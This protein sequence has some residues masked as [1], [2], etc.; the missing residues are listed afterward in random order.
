MTFESHTNLGIIDDVISEP[1]RS[2][3]LT[4][5][6]AGGPVPGPAEAH[7]RRRVKGK[8]KGN[9]ADQFCIYRTSDGGNIPTMAIEYKA[10][11]KLS[12]DEVVM[13]LASEIQPG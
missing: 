2:M 11:H 3:S 7:H 5:D 1:L 4:G 13:G 10:P 12:Q 9:R 8:G 6:G